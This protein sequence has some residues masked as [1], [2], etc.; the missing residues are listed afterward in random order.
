[1][2]EAAREHRPDCT[3]WLPSLWVASFFSLSCQGRSEVSMAP[4]AIA[5]KFSGGAGTSGCFRL[6]RIFRPRFFGNSHLSF[7]AASRLILLQMLFCQ[8]SLDHIPCLRS[9]TNNNILRTLEAMGVS[10]IDPDLRQKNA[11]RR[12]SMNLMFSCR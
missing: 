12:L 1:M 3:L 11:F 4:V 8:A 6:G 2:W 9:W 5:S 10:S 7:V